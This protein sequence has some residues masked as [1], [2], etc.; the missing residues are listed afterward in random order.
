[1]TERG[2]GGGAG[3]RIAAPLLLLDGALPVPRP[4]VFVSL[5]V[6]DPADPPPRMEPEARQRRLFALAKQIT[7][8]RSRREPSLLLFEDLHWIDDGSAP[9]LETLVDAVPGTRTLLVL[10]FRPD[11]HAAC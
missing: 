11:Y 3:G 4:L 5:G 7:H 6:A 10:T 2:G 8:A 9:F 1:S